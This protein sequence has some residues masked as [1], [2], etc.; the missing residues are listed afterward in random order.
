VGST[1]DKKTN[2]GQEKDAKFERNRKAKEGKI[3][4]TKAPLRFAGILLAVLGLAAFLLTPHV[5]S[6]NVEPPPKWEYKVLSFK[7]IALKVSGKEL[8]TLT[9][10]KQMERISTEL[11]KYS[12]EGWKISQT[13]SQS[14]DG[15]IIL[16]RLKPKK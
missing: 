4:N 9:L 2:E 1:W 3:M 13:L 10:E 7:D 8:N 15:Y 12:E 6:Q 5:N 11:N 14:G 16:E